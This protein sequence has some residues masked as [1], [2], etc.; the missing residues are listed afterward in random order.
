MRA[1]NLRTSIA[2]LA[3]L[4]LNG[5][6]VGPNYKTPAM[7]AP[8]A[9]SDSGH[10][11]DWAA[12]VPV[13]TAAPVAATAAFAAFL[14]RPLRDCFSIASAPESDLLKPVHGIEIH[15]IACLNGYT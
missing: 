11:G 13:T 14:M 8:P 4:A 6:M 1:P 9:Y 5:C 7:P 15:A 12:A 2:L 3:A 10:N